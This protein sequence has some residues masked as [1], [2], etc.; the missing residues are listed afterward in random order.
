MSPPTFLITGATGKQGGAAGRH[1]LRAGAQVRAL[2]RDPSSQSAQALQALGASLSHGSFD[3]TDSLQAACVDITAVF[4]NVSP[5]LSQ[6]GAELRHAENV[7]RAARTAGVSSIVYTSV[8]ETGQHETFPDWDNWPADS[9]LRHY[10]LNKAAIEDLV[11]HAGF[12]HYTIFRPPVFM[13]NFLLP[14]AKFLLPELATAG[15]LRTALAPEKR[16]MLMAPDDIG[17][18]VAEAMLNPE[19]YAGLERDIGGEALMMEQI[20]TAFREVSGKNVISEFIPEPE[21]IVLSKTNVQVDVQRW[22]WERLDNFDPKVL[23]EWSGIRLTSLKEFLEA[24]ID[25]VQVMIP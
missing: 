16:T 6:P 12:R 15:V 20:A 4:L 22:M 5:D 10:F 24:N 21:A 14:D 25:T 11:R 2:V 13:S 1:L 19:K 7:V 8:C 23:E 17:R 18:F 3:D 9:F